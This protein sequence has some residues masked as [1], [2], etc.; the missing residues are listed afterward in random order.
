MSPIG[1]FIRSEN[2][3]IIDPNYIL[4]GRVRTI[5]NAIGCFF[6]VGVERCLSL[7]GT[8]KSVE[9]TRG[10]RYGKRILSAISNHT[11]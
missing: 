2:S 7:N 4:H 10:K 11:N 9:V 3:S 6:I 1:T 8:K 5:S